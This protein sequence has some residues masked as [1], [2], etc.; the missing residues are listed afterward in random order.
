MVEYKKKLIAASP[1]AGVASVEVL[2]CRIKHFPEAE[3]RRQKTERDKRGCRSLLCSL[4]ASTLPPA[5]FMFPQRRFLL[6]LSLSS[7]SP[8]SCL[9]PSNPFPLSSQSLSLVRDRLFRKIQ[10][11][12]VWQQDREERCGE[13]GGASRSGTLRPSHVRPVASLPLLSP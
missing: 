5:S 11:R 1:L 10:R 13:S 12:P 2:R 6:L 7:F 4:E 3:G 9:S 8:S